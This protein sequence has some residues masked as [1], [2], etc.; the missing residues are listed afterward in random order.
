HLDLSSSSI[1]Y[2]KENAFTNLAKLKSL[3]L[4]SNNLSTLSKKFFKGLHSL[5]ELDHN[6][7]TNLPEG[8]YQDLEKL[9]G[10]RLHHNKRE[11]LRHSHLNGL[12]HL[13]ALVAHNNKLTSFKQG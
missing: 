4:S 3:S 5:I 8:I 10:L 6:D 13:K 7:L 12:K 11:E 1:I 2:M 9:K